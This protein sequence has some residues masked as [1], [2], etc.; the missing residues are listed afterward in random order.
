LRFIELAIE[1]MGP[2]RVRS[3]LL[4]GLEPAEDTLR[5]V[6]ALAQRGCEPVLSPFRPDPSTPLGKGRNRIPPP[7][8]Q[9]I[10]EVFLRATD[11]AAKHGMRLG[12]RCVPCMHNTITLPDDSGFY[13]KHGDVRFI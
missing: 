2:G 4:V 10:T 5:G 1:H 3:L 9:T 11:I 7:N 13:T 6:E 8:Q 12:P